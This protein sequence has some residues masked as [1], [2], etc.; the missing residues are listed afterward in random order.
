MRRCHRPERCTSY[1]RPRGRGLRG[2]FLPPATDTYLVSG[3][4]GVWL[5]KS[6][7]KDYLKNAEGRWGSLR[8]VYPAENMWNDNPYYILD[9][10]NPDRTR[11]AGAAQRSCIAPSKGKTRALYEDRASGGYAQDDLAAIS[12][13]DL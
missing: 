1:V 3:M 8:V 13:N 5:G 2:S 6:T 9:V 12:N 7:V 10:P 11:H 4:E